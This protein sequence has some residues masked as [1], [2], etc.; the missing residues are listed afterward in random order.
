MSDD[1]Q[2]LD[3]A[4]ERGLSRIAGRSA[5]EEVLFRPHP[6][7]LDGSLVAW[8]SNVIGKLRVIRRTYAEMLAQFGA[9][10]TRGHEQDALRAFAISD[11][12]GGVGYL[13]GARVPD[14]TGVP[15]D[16]LAPGVRLVAATLAHPSELAYA[17]AANDGEH[18]LALFRA[19]GERSHVSS[20]VRPPVV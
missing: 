13:L 19:L 15:I 12:T 5:G 6:G 20:C 8:P 4:L 17:I 14:V 16:E 11:A 2:I 18:V 10:S 1:P 3:E 9:I 7:V